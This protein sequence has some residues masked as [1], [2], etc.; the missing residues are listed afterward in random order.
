M[1]VLHY[2]KHMDACVG[3]GHEKEIKDAVIRWIEMCPKDDHSMFGK[4]N[5]RKQWSWEDM[6]TNLKYRIFVDKS[7]LYILSRI[8][9]EPIGVFLENSTW[10]SCDLQGDT[11]GDLCIVFE[12]GVDKQFIPIQWASAD[13]TDDLI[14]QCEFIVEIATVVVI[15][16]IVI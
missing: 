15:I 5:T 7:V 14:E 12:M 3:V 13:E 10:A 4:C 6:V 16:L 8:L 9:S 11:V 1:L 2:I